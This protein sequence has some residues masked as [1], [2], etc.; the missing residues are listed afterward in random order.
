M[1]IKSSIIEI[2]NLVVKPKS[3]TVKSNS[4]QYQ[5]SFKHVSN[6]NQWQNFLK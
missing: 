1:I 6:K 2:Q 5:L 3:Q 4:E